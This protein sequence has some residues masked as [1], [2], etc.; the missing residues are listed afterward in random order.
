LLLLVPSILAAPVV[1]LVLLLLFVQLA[2]ES[3]A[4]L[5]V[6]SVPSLPSDLEILLV[7]E[8]PL[9]LVDLLGL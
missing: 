5:A 2:L 7:L 4:L 3:L 9:D 1:L 8:G 6:L